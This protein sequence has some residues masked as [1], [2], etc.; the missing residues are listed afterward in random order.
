MVQKTRVSTT[1]SQ[2]ALY[3][4]R[5]QYLGNNHQMVITTRFNEGSLYHWYKLW[6]KQ[7]FLTLQIA[8]RCFFGPFRALCRNVL[9]AV[10]SHRRCNYYPFQWIT[11]RLYHL[12]AELW[13][14][15]CFI[16]LQSV[17]WDTVCLYF[18]NIIMRKDFNYSK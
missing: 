6:Y 7:C 13:H 2:T 8:Y 1:A 15:H 17:V 12:M 5:K 11:T 3:K 18:F 9:I 10:N 16:T 14:K 4:V